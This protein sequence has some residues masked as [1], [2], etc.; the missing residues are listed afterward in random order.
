MKPA[1]HLRLTLM[2]CGLICFAIASEAASF[3]IDPA[4]SRFEIHTG[5]SGFLS[6]FGHDHIISAK[7]IKGCADID[8]SQIE[9]SS[10]NLTFS[11]AGVTVLDP[12]HPNDRPKVQETM[13]NEILRVKEFPEIRFKSDRVRL[14]QPAPG[15]A[16]RYD[17]I[18]DGPLTIRGQTRQ[19]SIPLTVQ[20]GASNDASVSGHYALKQSE[21]GIKPISLAGGTVKVKDDM[22]LDFDLRLRETR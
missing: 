15:A 5:T 17:L 16:N 18:V 13:E 4:G 19:V 14:R 8:W 6:A 9:H 21:F 11:T 10:V 2:S 22:Q 1:F 12:K 7:D 3:C 20:R